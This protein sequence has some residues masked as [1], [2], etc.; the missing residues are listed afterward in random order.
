MGKTYT[1]SGC[2]VALTLSKRARCRKGGSVRLGAF[3]IGWNLQPYLI[4]S[5]CKRHCRTLK[6]AKCTRCTKHNAD[7]DKLSWTDH[8]RGLIQARRLR[9][10]LGAQDVEDI[11]KPLPTF[12]E[13]NQARHKAVMCRMMRH[14]YNGMVHRYR[15]H[16]ERY[17]EGESKRVVD[18]KGGPKKRGPRSGGKSRGRSKPPTTE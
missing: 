1:A 4:C 2:W 5:N 11:T 15:R 17:L 12:E 8:R 3:S 9:E 14:R 6:A 10:R 16:V 7:R 18:A 13:V